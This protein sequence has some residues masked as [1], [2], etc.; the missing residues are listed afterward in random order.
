[1]T[2]GVIIV[3]VGI[4]CCLVG[5]EA[6]CHRRKKDCARLR[7]LVKELAECLYGNPCTGCK[8]HSCAVCKHRREMDALVAKARKEVTK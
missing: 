7:A 5:A 8:M 2:C 3:I 4:M 6:E 1:M